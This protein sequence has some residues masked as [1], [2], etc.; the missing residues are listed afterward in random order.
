MY[1]NY[2]STSLTMCIFL[3]FLI[4]FSAESQSVRQSG[5]SEFGMV[6]TAHPLATEVGVSILEHG[7]NAAD[8]AVATGFAIAIVEPT[9]N[10]IGGRNQIL[11]R[12]S[13]GNFHG[14]DGT[15]QAPLGYDPETAPQAS[16]GYDVIGIPGVPAGLLRLHEQF[17]S[18]PLEILMEPA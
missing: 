4:P 13:D 7:G 17:G 16:Y 15:T 3:S 8:A 14:I 9:M 5:E 2:L 10:S 18:L 1:L 12:T 6:S 11:I